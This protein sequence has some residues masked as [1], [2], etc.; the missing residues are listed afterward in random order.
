M[1]ANAASSPWHSA[2]NDASRISVRPG[3]ERPL[4]D[5]SPSARRAASIADAVEDRYPL[6]RIRA[7]VLAC[8]TAAKDSAPPWPPL[9]Y[10]PQRCLYQPGEM[11]PAP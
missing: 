11:T 7:A 9:E 10:S 4:T 3:T 8:H 5:A 2:D 1:A 6:S